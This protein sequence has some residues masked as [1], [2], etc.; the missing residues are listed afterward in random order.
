MIELIWSGWVSGPVGGQAWVARS[1]SKQWFHTA[2]DFFIFFV[3]AFI[4]LLLP[5]AGSLT[6]LPSSLRPCCGSSS[7]RPRWCWAGLRGPHTSQNT[8]E[9]CLFHTFLYI[10][11]GVM[12]TTVPLF[13]G[14]SLF[15]LTG[16]VI[17]LNNTMHQP[18]GP[19]VYIV[20]SLLFALQPRLLPHK[21]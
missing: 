3:P 6:I 5:C 1:G 21:Y 19:G 10:F 11:C 12:I 13:Y 16:L 20:I 4:K 15:E 7:H 17:T 2:P 18:P 8:A 14:G 9:F